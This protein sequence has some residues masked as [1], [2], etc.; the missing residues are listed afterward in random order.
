MLL[1]AILSLTGLASCV[2]TSQSAFGGAGLPLTARMAGLLPADAFLYGSIRVDREH[3]LVDQAFRESKFANAADAATKRTSS[4]VYAVADSAGHALSY[5]VVASGEYPLGAI[6]LQLSPSAGWKRTNGSPTTW[7][8]QKNG[9]RLAF[10]SRKL[11]LLSN[12]DLAPMLGRYTRPSPPINYPAVIHSMES[13]DLVA[14][15]PRVGAWI[16]SA[17]GDPNRFPAESIFV[18][19]NSV[20]KSYSAS[21]VLVM[22]DAQAARLFSVIFRLLISAGAS[23]GPGGLPVSFAGASVEVQGSR[24]D[25]ANLTIDRPKLAAVLGEVLSGRVP[26]LSTGAGA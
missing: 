25:L 19:V 4:L 11:A 13:A 8:N 3:S 6:S 17:G 2:T 1:A 16:E 22:K 5:S 23:G 20:G 9:W 12:V 10:P 14:Y 18:S 21:A 15:A 26:L 24:I 7:T